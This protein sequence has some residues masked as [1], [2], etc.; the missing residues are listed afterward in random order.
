[1]DPVS[2]L[3]WMELL[4]EH[5]GGHNSIR[6]FGIPKNKNMI[7]QRLEPVF[8]LVQLGLRPCDRY[9]RSYGPLNNGRKSMD[10]WG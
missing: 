8:G 4:H 2:I 5:F 3:Q 10:N 6:G 9:K 1:M 7:F